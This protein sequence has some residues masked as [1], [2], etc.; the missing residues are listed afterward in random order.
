MKTLVTT[1]EEYLDHCN[2]NNGFCVKC[3]EIQ[4]GGCE[5]DAEEYP[6]ENCEE[7]GVYGIELALAMGL[8]EI[9]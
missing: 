3:G 9:E 4:E 6:C 1:E 7:N 8:V 2:S 5:P